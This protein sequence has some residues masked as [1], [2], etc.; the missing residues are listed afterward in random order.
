VSPLDLPQ[1]HA[2]E[3]A[4]SVRLRVYTTWIFL[5]QKISM[6]HTSMKVGVDF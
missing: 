3:R 1:F 6:K 4:D 5:D 2:A